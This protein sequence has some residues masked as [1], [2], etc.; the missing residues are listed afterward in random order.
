LSAPP[1]SLGAER[2]LAQAVETA[3]RATGCPIGVFYLCG[4]RHIEIASVFGCTAADAI[5]ISGLAVLKAAREQREGLLILHEATLAHNLRLNPPW[6]FSAADGPVRFVAAAHVR[7]AQRTTCGLLLVADRVPHAPITNEQQDLLRAHAAR[8][9]ELLEQHAHQQAQLQRHGI[10]GGPPD[11]SAQPAQDAMM[12]TKA[13]PDAAAQHIVSCNAAFAR[14]TGYGEMEL[15]GLSPEVI[16]A[17]AAEGESMDHLQQALRHKRTIA[18]AVTLRHKNGTE[19]P[20]EILVV[21]TAGPEAALTR[22]FVVPQAIAGREIP[23]ERRQRAGDVQ[24][25]NQALEQEKAALETEVQERERIEARLHYLAFHDTL[26]SVYNRQFFMDRLAAALEQLTIDPNLHFAV[27]LLD[28]DGF[29]S[30]NDSFGHGAGDLMLIEIADRLT[31]SVRADDI[32]ARVGG[33]EFAI[34]VQ[35]FEKPGYVASM[36]ERVVEVV[37]HAVQLGGQEVFSSA[38]IGA[39]FATKYYRLPEE[40]LRDADIAMYEAKRLRAGFL[41]FDDAMHR[42]AIILSRFRNE[43]QRAVK[44]SEFYIEYQPIFDLA[45]NRITG[46]EALVRWQHPTRGKLLPGEFI[47]TAEEMGLIRQIGAQVLR[48]A[49]RQMREWHDVYQDFGLRL[50][51]NISAHELADGQ[52]ISHLEEILNDT[53]LSPACLQLD[54]QESALWPR[55]EPN[56]A[57]LRGIRS[58]GARVAVDDFGTGYSSLGDLEGYPIDAIKIGRALIAGIPE[59]RKTLAIVKAIIDLARALDFEVIAEGLERDAQIQALWSIGCT[60]AQGF[61]LSKPL[62]VPAGGRLPLNHAARW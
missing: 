24:V 23:V 32:V 7:Y 45:T 17:S 62:S 60:Q 21:P 56:L 5:S 50:S 27:L 1:E 10:S 52:F 8:I 30:V 61:I 28:L 33:D 22:W 26:T 41:I 6:L 51:V 25:R 31:K 19:I 59:R 20:A 36:A 29:K 12:I 9:S 43:L 13:D 54:I 11:P 39:A 46:M 57:A 16:R 58:L 47:G 2:V 42:G 49:C 3:A 38:S 40:I 15:V 4:K 35:G 18:V 37:R 53:G 55:P 44:R 48:G 14:L 34:L